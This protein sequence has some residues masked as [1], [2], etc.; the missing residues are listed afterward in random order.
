MHTLTLYS[1]MCQLHLNEEWK[2]IILKNVSI[3]I[4]FDFSKIN[5]YKIR[6]II[7]LK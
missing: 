4:K 1:V 6:K 5:K 3:K 2:K 7:L